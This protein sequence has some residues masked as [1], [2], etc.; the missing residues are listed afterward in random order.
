MTVGIAKAWS[1]G[2]DFRIQTVTV[3]GYVICIDWL[4]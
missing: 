3:D 1:E 2:D 4:V